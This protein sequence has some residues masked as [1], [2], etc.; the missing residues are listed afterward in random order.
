[1]TKFVLT[2]MPIFATGLSYEK[3]NEYM[4]KANNKFGTMVRFSMILEDEHS[5][6]GKGKWSLRGS[7]LSLQELF[8]KNPTEFILD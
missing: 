3:A 8:L 2:S 7:I 1:M 4:E 5:E 6:D